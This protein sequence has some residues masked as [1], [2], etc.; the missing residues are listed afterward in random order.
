MATK[1]KAIQK[2]T[3]PT[4]AA[5]LAS[6]PEPRRAEM[7]RLHALVTATVPHL[8]PKVVSGMIAY[9]SYHYRYETGRTGVSSRIAISSRAGGISVYVSAVDDK[10]WLAEQ[11]AK[12][13]GKI[14]VGKSCIR[15][16]KVD[17]LA[18]EAFTDLLRRAGQGRAPGEVEP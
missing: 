12:A 13:L 16:R 1:K 5:Y 3:Q 11:A 7:K 4:P 2:E 14:D 18:L 8:A 9:G 17:D 6:L 15:V 10:G